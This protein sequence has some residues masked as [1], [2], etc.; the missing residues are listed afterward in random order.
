MSLCRQLFNRPNHRK[1]VFFLSFKFDLPFIMRKIFVLAILILTTVYGYAQPKQ[2]RLSEVKILFVLDVSGS[3]NAEWDG[4][5]RINAAQDILLNLADSLQI[6]YPNVRFALRVFGADYPRE[7][8][9][10]K[11]S[12][13]LVSFKDYSY[14]TLKNALQKLVPRG[15]TPI[16]YTLEKAAGDFPADSNLHTIILITDG[17]ENCDG[18]P[19]KAA[20]KLMKKRI[21][22]RPFIVGM[23]VSEK[24]AEKFSC[25]GEFINTNSSTEMSNTVNVII[26]QTL[27]NTSA[28]INLLDKQGKPTVTNI[29]FTLY[30]SE[31]GKE[32]FS[33]VHQINI[34][35]NPD[36]IYLNPLGIYTLV[37]HT[38]PPI[39]KENIEL[40]L[41]RHNIIAVDAPIGNYTTY[42]ST[43]AINENNAQVVLRDSSNAILNSQELVQVESYLQNDY[44]V[45]VLTIPPYEVSANII[46]AE[47][48]DL[49]IPAFGTLSLNSTE[50]R[51]IAIL[52][53]QESKWKK[54]LEIN[55]N[56]KTENIKLQ[57]GEYKVVY[58]KNN[59]ITTQST[60]IKNFVVEE[61]RYISLSL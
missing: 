49:K 57:P 8:R 14:S 29:P 46:A 45:D 33:Y 30:D 7:Q 32:E 5:K 51:K 17:E 12:R 53:R 48:K 42:C 21:S 16:T 11:D 59:A 44:S 47:N 4:K 6:K 18:D 31:T 20:E 28:Q 37:V 60:Q 23:G 2:S 40:G 27:N 43:S 41:G 13:L 56:N 52:V 36:T 22:F 25:I 15:M 39:K 1:V 58:Q 61:S 3:M 24:A 26:K 10:C 19:C 9:N 50:N 35:G 55:I 38:F 54:V 34:S